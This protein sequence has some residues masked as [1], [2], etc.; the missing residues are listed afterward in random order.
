V[1]SAAVGALAY[2]PSPEADK[3][4]LKGVR[5]EIRLVRIRAAS[6]LQQRPRRGLSADDTA[7]YNAAIKE[8][9]NSFLIWPD[10]WSSHYNLGL[11]YAREG[12][13][14][15]ALGAFEKASDL[16][17]DVIQP[18]VNASMLYA[19]MRN[20]VEVRKL[21]NK[22]LEISPEDPVVNL[23]LALLE[24]EEK[25]MGKSEQY[26]RAALAGDPR[27]AQAAYNLG[28]LLAQQNRS[29]GL[30][31]CRK[32]AELE[33]ETGAYAYTYAFF[34]VQDKKMQEAVD[35]LTESLKVVPE[36]ADSRFLLANLYQQQGEIVKARQVYLQMMKNESL[37][38][39]V[40]KRASMIMGR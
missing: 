24:A 36:Y 16:R 38:L 2:D 3:V 30:E 28:I 11:F 10:R 35:V 22:V 23:N 18:L 1:R 27:M 5:D 8:Y 34:L 9:E 39:S 12:E 17:P 33:P 13:T 40:R 6:S 15:R 32:A 25:N 19:G 7:A 20:N 26:F 37:P 14:D 29:E 31:W 21:L 4:L